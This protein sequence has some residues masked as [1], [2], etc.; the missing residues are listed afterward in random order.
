MP[1]IC[2][3]VHVTDD[4]LGPNRT[5]GQM[6][7]YANKITLLLCKPNIPDTMFELKEFVVQ[8]LPNLDTLMVIGTDHT[9][10]FD[11][12][13]FVSS[14]NVRSNCIET[15]RELDFKVVNSH[16]QRLQRKKISSSHSLPCM[17]SIA[18]H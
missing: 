11:I 10:D 16:R 5:P 15:M 18:E 17:P 13:V 3:N 8:V 9:G 6:T 14:P 12:Y 4:I 7:V 2:I 1:F